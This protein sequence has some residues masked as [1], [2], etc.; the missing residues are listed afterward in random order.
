MDT[1]IGLELCTSGYA[2]KISCDGKV[3]VKKGT[4]MV[5]SPLFPMLETYRSADY[6]SVIL[7]EELDKVLPLITHHQPTPQTLAIISPF[8]I[9]DEKQ[10]AHFLACTK[11]IKEQE[12]QLIGA[13]H[14]IERRVKESIIALRKQQVML[15]H[16]LFFFLR[17]SK[18]EQEIP[19]KRQV[20][21]RFMVSVNQHFAE[22]RSVGYYAEQ[23]H[24][25]P[26]HF[27]DIIRK[28]SGYT[29]MQWIGLVT[30]NRAKNLLQQPE[31]QVKEVASELGFPEQFT[32]R[33]YFK[34]HTGMSPRAYQQSVQ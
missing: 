28:E 21:V 19:S 5:L 15:E 9:L 16:A 23:E 7:Y 25:T 17:A 4:L 12:Q 2:E 30:I 29:P 11:Q 3:T 13:L 34:T 26:R 18:S 27:A 31:K 1:K 33:K 6:T 32:F 22:H 24:M 20:L 14:P 8:L 10:Y